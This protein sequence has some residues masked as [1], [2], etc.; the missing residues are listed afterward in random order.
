MVSF[1][2]IM[3]DFSNDDKNNEVS[4]RLGMSYVIF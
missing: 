4:H 3:G 1:V 2:L